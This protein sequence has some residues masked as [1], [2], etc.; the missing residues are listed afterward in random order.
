[1]AQLWQTDAS[2]S[3]EKRIKFHKIPPNYLSL[4][5]ENIATAR[6]STINETTCTPTLDELPWPVAIKIENGSEGTIEAM[7]RRGEATL[8]R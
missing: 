6:T 3:G 2:L 5:T 8:A 1:M 7:D 4:R